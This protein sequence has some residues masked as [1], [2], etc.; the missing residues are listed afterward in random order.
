VA[1]W[2]CLDGAA[3]ILNFS[4]M[5]IDEMTIDAQSRNPGFEFSG[6]I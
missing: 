4:A 3:D 2:V 6:I 1:K 5:T